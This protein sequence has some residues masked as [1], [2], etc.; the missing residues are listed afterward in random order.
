G[1][2][3]EVEARAA[4]Y[5][6]TH[7]ERTGMLAAIAKRAVH[8]PEQMVRKMVKDLIADVRHHRKIINEWEAVQ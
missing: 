3:Y 7:I 2:Y 6:G 4:S 1:D 8:L 5:L